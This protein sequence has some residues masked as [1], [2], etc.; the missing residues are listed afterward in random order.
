MTPCL[1]PDE[2]I[3][4]VDGALPA[5][6]Q[7]HLDDCAACAATAREVRL[8]LDL[9]TAA[10]VPEPPA[11]FWSS[12][13]ARVR[14][15]VAET[16]PGWRAWLRWDVVVPIAGLAVVMVALAT[17]IEHRL[18]AASSPAATV[19]AGLDD[20]VAD[21]EPPD[22][23]LAMMI[24]LADSLPEGG[25]DALG[26]SRLPDIDIAAAAL[27]ADEQRALADLLQSAVE[28]PKS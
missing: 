8:A 21:G 11:L 17:T 16:S 1:T 24:D 15:A 20:Q 5:S 3:D 23:A 28:R 4:L 18:P 12:V 22:D 6:R 13:N 25:W 26:V 19:G 14:A 2:F 9:A 7:S 10:P 27:S